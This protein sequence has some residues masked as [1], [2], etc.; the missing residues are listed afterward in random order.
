MWRYW[1][2]G[3]CQLRPKNWRDTLFDYVV[4]AG[5]VWHTPDTI[6]TWAGGVDDCRAGSKK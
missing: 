4:N 5:M 6:P 1:V 3:S 2:I